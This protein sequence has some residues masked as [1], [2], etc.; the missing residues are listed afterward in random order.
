MEIGMTAVRER[1]YKVEIE[2]LQKIGSFRLRARY[3]R[4]ILGFIKSK[5]TA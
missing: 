1:F 5:L 2:D 4:P 3:H